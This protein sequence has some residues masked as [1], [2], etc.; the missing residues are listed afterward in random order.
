MTKIFWPSSGSQQ[1][2]HE[3]QQFTKEEADP[4]LDK[5]IKMMHNPLQKVLAAAKNS[6]Y[7]GI[8]KLSVV[9]PGPHFGNGRN[10]EDPANT[11]GESKKFPPVFPGRSPIMFTATCYAGINI[12]KF[13]QLELQSMNLVANHIA[14]K[15]TKMSQTVKKVDTLD[16]LESEL[17]SWVPKFISDAKAYAKVLSVP[18]EDTA[19]SSDQTKRMFAK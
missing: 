8:S 1:S 17:K 4:I 7:T 15:K 19:S 10:I 13:G 12:S 6:G 18:P 14:G 9:N 2:W 3:Y 16:T 5:Y 11:T